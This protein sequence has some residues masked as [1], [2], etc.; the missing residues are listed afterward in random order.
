MVPQINIARTTAIVSSS[1]KTVSLS[2][3]SSEDKLANGDRKPNHSTRLPLSPNNTAPDP[4]FG[5]KLAS[6]KKNKMFSEYSNQWDAAV[7]KTGAPVPT[8][9]APRTN[10]TSNWWK[11]WKHCSGSRAWHWWRIWSSSSRSYWSSYS[12]VL[13]IKTPADALELTTLR[14]EAEAL[15][16]GVQ[17]ISSQVEQKGPESEAEARTLKTMLLSLPFLVL[18][19]Q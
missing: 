19:G 12:N 5:S 8:G 18:L 3:T 13:E 7:P 11:R 9:Q 4:D 17:E 14:T 16:N 2:C 1:P 15:I 6:V 10:W